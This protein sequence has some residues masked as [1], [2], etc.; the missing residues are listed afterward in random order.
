MRDWFE[1]FKQCGYIIWLNTMRISLTKEYN[2]NL[3]EDLLYIKLLKI[4]IVDRK[5]SPV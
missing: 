3:K 4:E 1:H 2:S 5:S